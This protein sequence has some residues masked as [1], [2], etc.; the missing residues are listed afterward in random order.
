MPRWRA[1]GLRLIAALGL[2]VAQAASIAWWGHGQA[3]WWLQLLSLAGLVA[4][5]HHHADTVLREPA[6]DTWPQ[7]AAASRWRR[8]WLGL[9]RSG[10]LQ[11]FGWGWLYATAW[12]TA[13]V[14]W[15]FISMHV[16]GGLAAPLAA[17][18][19]LALAAFL[20]LYYGVAAAAYHRMLR[21]L[22]ARGLQDRVRAAWW[23]PLA[24][25]AL[26]TL[27]EWARGTWLTGFPWGATGY[28]HVDGPLVSLA[29]WVGVY[30]MGWVAAWWAAL[31]AAV[32]VRLASGTRPTAPGLR[33]LAL[34]TSQTMAL[35][36]SLAAC[37][38][39][40]LVHGGFTRPTGELSVQ[41]L[42]GNI[43]Q[44]EKFEFGPGINRSLAWYGQALQS[45]TAPLVVTAE[46][47]IPL[48][49][50]QLPTRYWQ[51]IQAPFTQPGSARAAIVAVPL[52]SIEAGYTNSVRTFAAGPA[53]Q[54]RYD[55]HHLV[56]FGEFIPAGFHWFVRM[57]NIPLGDFQRGALPQPPLAWQGERI[58]PNICYEDLFGEEIGAGFGDAATAPTV[59][60]NLSNIAWFGDSIA[61]DQHLAIS[62]LRALEFERPM[63]RATNT[64]TTALIDHT[65][66]VVRALPRLTAGVLD[67]TVQGRDGRTPYARWVAPWGLWP[68]VLACLGLLAG[69]LWRLQL[70]GRQADV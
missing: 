32:L 9:R 53:G 8:T 67:V 10:S 20:A 57:M 6:P 40:G 52:G 7:Q 1:C 70:W 31:L 46:T 64:G 50:T 42:Q 4:L 24:F 12:L 47:A 60:L 15:L 30:G 19:V 27:A 58:A 39:L 25:A 45:S 68:L 62:R 38:V 21:A 55:K 14:W 28:A 48:L 26:W 41:L 13:T 56:P 29:P 51:A 11:A 69:A 2:G 59:L 35:A 33:G 65:G 23:L 36:G 61:I 16:Y 66:R 22:R 63:L 37:A 18:A 34:T 43:P 17:L 54:Y 3:V 49:P 44:D 5:L